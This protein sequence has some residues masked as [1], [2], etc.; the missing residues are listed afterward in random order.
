MNNPSLLQNE[1]QQEVRDN[2]RQNDL[3]VIW[4]LFKKNWY[5]FL[6]AI[7]FAL[8]CARFHIG[9]TLPVFQTSATILI[10]ETDE[11]RL[12]DNSELL[13]GLGLPG[14]MKNLENQIMIIK[15]KSLAEKTLKDLPF[16]V[17]Y[18]NKTIRTKIMIYPDI[19]IVVTYKDDNSIPKDNEFSISYQGNNMFTIKSESDNFSFQKTASFGDTIEIAG[20]ALCV[21]YR[22]AEWLQNNI[23]NKIYF[24]INSRRKLINHF[25]SRLNVE[26]VSRGGSILKITMNGTN[27]AMDVA[28]LNRHLENFQSISLDTK[29]NEAERRIQ[30][31]N[32]QLIGISDSLSI[33]ENRLQQFR[34]AN[35][36][37][38]LSAQ[39]QAI[40]AQVTLLENEKA[41]LEL[42]ANYYDYLAEYLSKEVTGELPI[43]PITMGIT[44]PGLTRLVEEMSEL[45][46]QLA[47]T[48]A[49]QMNPLQ[50]NLQQKVTSTKS[51]LSETLNGLR[52]ANSLARSEN[53]TQI[54]RANTQ[55]SSLPVTERQL[56]GIERKFKLNDELYTFL[57]ETLAEQQMQK[58]SNRADSEVID[59]ADI[60]FVSILSPNPTK[61]YLIGFLAALVFTFL[62]IYLRFVFNNKI[63]EEDIKKITNIPVVGNIPHISEDTNTIVLDNPESSIAEAFRL[64]RSRMQFFTKEAKSPIILLTSS[65]PGEGKTF[66][67]INL[68]S[69]YSLLD[70]K[71]VLVGFDLRKPKIFQDFNVKNERGVSTWLIGQDKLQDIIQETEYKNLSIIPAGP[72]PPNPSEL[73]ALKKTEELLT[74]LKEKFD[75]IIIDTPPIGLVSD[76]YHLAS[77]ADACLLVVRP[78]FTLKDILKNTLVEV[79]A[80]GM[81]EVSL[82]INDLK[83][84]SRHYGYGGKYGYTNEKGKLKK[85]SRKRGRPV[86]N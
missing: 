58:A 80:S 78:G 9:H 42:E 4:T 15:S 2:E 12:V 74:L 81:K 38:D 68:A 39:G 48:G 32:D 27:P 5:Y 46:G 62:F 20:S 61:V 64:L 7:V 72:V 85:R 51:A 70:K 83:S 25:V 22:D 35:R 57:L 34:S 52:R 3:L 60:R 24:L 14:G 1:H 11:R 76:T 53:Q 73:I 47:T 13:Q 10:Q 56:L 54:N 67:S 26:L 63:K 21:N 28:F 79:N 71:T 16:E 18:Y 33:T 30:F 31:V 69:I 45:Q 6:I 65:S 82:I 19:P 29:N 44:D 41:R 36:V 8:A 49:G 50:R 55:A 75:F 17:S 23:G 40:I 59:N 37:M 84:D 86:L 77:L 43:V 66:A